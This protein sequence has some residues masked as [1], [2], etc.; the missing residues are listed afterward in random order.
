MRNPDGLR[1]PHMSALSRSPSRATLQS[2]A[3]A[4]ILIVV[5]LILALLV[6]LFLEEPL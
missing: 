2:S 6:L 5:M 4:W 3:A 1:R